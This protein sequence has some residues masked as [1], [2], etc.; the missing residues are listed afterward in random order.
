[1]SI[2]QHIEKG[3]EMKGRRVL[4]G[5]GDRKTIW[6]CSALG[7]IHTEGTTIEITLDSVF[8]P[9]QSGLTHRSPFYGGKRQ[10]GG[11]EEGVDSGFLTSP[12]TG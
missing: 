1:M 10:R 9:M 7:Y 6:T 8:N 2:G 3:P 5:L 11:V 4:V 12:T